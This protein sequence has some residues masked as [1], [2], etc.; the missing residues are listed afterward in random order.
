MRRLPFRVSLALVRRVR[1]VRSTPAGV[2]LPTLAHPRR[3][4]ARTVTSL[5]PV[6]ACGWS[7]PSQSCARV[8][9]ANTPRSRE[10]S[11]GVLA[12]VGVLILREA[13]CYWAYLCVEFDLL[14]D[15]TRVYVAARC[16]CVSPL[17]ARQQRS[18]MCTS[19]AQ[20]LLRNREMH[21]SLLVATALTRDV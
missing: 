9:S 16:A 20:S 1:E 10:G 13:Y 18:D 5:Q 7:F 17:C 19:F 8:C 12:R 11:W 2:I 14:R 6:S 4:R 15:A 3:T 21:R